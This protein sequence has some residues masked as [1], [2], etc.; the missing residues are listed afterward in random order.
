MANKLS[1]LDAEAAA[2]LAQMRELPVLTPKHKQQIT[3][4]HPAELEPLS[5]RTTM[6]ETS[7]TFTEAQAVLEAMRCMHCKKPF[8]SAACPIGMPIPEY[9]GHLVS[10]DIQGAIDLI[11]EHSLFPS[12]CSRVCPHEKQCESNC[13]VGKMQKDARK[14][15]SIGNIERFCSDY[16]RYKLGGKKVPEMAASTGKRVAV[17]GAGPAGLAAAI[18]LATFGHKVEIFEAAEGLGGVLRYGI[19]EFR[20]PK[21]I[22]DYELSILP[23]MGIECYTG[24]TVGKDFP[25]EN[26]LN[27]QGFDAV[28]LG[29][30]AW[31]ALTT[32]VPGEDLKGVFTAEE[33]LKK[34][35]LQQPIDSGKSVVIVGGGN[36]AMDAS[37]MAFRLGAEK[38][39]IVYRRTKEQMPACMVELEE[40]TVEGVEI[41]ELRNPSEFVANEEGRVC[42]AKLDV[43]KLGEPDSSGRA[44]PEKIE[45]EEDFVECDTVVLAI[46]SKVSPEVKASAPELETNRNGTYIVKDPETGETSISKVYTG[47]D[48]MHGPQTVVLAMKTGRSA[49]K[50]IHKM[51]VGEA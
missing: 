13:T 32:G 40:A 2:L 4:Q 46:G 15:V 9:F 34:G 14:C 5:R 18:D 8:C 12:I 31:L 42:G 48:A 7:A 45:G 3:R 33:Y 38:V 6:E 37:R 25:L 21:H 47:G 41:R 35:N 24:V 23:K 26:L 43:F 36:V 44:R 28:F 16:E 30:G 22:L 10:G 51:L 19:P 29:N 27:E 50:A 20:L 39:T 49:A 11:R 1:E 17:V